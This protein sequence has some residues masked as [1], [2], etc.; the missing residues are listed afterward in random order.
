MKDSE[1]GSQNNRITFFKD[2]VNQI[3]QMLKRRGEMSL[4]DVIERIDHHYSHNA[5]AKQCI[6]EMCRRGVIKEFRFENGKLILT[7]NE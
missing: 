2:T 1:A 6:I 7:E 5:S 3:T 4:K